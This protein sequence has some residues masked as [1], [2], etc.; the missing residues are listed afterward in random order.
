VSARYS[1]LFLLV[2][3]VL[4]LFPLSLLSPQL[5]ENKPADFHHVAVTGTKNKLAKRTAAL[6]PGRCHESHGG[7]IQLLNTTINSGVI[8][9]SNLQPSRRS[10]VLSGITAFHQAAS[11]NRYTTVPSSIELIVKLL[12]EEVKYGAEMRVL[13]L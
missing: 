10:G 1:T 12:F 4:T 3:L 2:T 13:R 6:R 8:T 11:R 7:I 5:R 9:E